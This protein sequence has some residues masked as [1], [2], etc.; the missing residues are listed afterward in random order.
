MLSYQINVKRKNTKFLRW[1]KVAEVIFGFKKHVK[2][3]WYKF[4]TE[5]K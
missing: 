3:N 5:E 4:G 2:E 1:R